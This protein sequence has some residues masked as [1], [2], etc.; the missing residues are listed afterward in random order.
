[1]PDNF[2]YNARDNVVTAS[3]KICISVPVTR[4]DARDI[5]GKTKKK[6]RDTF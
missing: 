3:E 1:M 6:Q 5:F 2:A 4:K